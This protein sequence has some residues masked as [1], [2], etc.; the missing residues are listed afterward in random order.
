MIVGRGQDEL[1]DRTP[2]LPERTRIYQHPALDSTRWDGFAPRAGDI[3]V[4]TSYKTGTTWMQTILSLLIFDGDPPAPPL[5]LSP[6]LDM[7][8]RPLDDVLSQL[9]AQNHRRFVKSHLPLDAL[10]FYPEV[11]YIVVVRDGRDVLMSMWNH[12]TAYTAESLAR[13]NDAP[14]RFGVLP[15]A[16]PDVGTFFDEWV[17]RS[18][19]PWE[20]DGYPYWSHHHHL[21]TFWPHR[22]REN[23]LLVHFND[24]LAD[25]DGEMRRVARFIDVPLPHR[26]P[27][28]V[29]A[30]T[31]ASMK[32]NAEALMPGAERMFDGGARRFI[33]KGENGRWRGVLSARQLDAYETLLSQT[34]SPDCATWLKQ[35]GPLPA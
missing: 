8:L 21:A 2:P 4:S 35:G 6:W 33:Y 23:V 14:E 7:R 9:E 17:S 10:P 24:L 18:W 16:P 3:V 11:R 1:M 22:F 27:E 28:L 32:R 31:F 15:P 19:F 5:S 29:E 13:F 25:L 20:R 26:F 12:H 30:A 34:L